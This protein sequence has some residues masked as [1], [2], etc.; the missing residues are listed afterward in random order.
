[1]AVW[2]RIMATKRINAT[3]AQNNF[4]RVID[5]AIQNRVR[6]IIHRR[7]VPHVVVLSIDEL[8]RLLGDE[9][10]RQHLTTLLEQLRPDY[11]LGQVLNTPV[12]DKHGKRTPEKT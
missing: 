8:I 12:A 10:E 1:M 5:D 9:K 3:E 4:G 7:N 11:G 6:Y 2:E